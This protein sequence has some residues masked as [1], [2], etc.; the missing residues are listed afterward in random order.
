MNKLLSIS[1]GAV[2][3]F[4]LQGAA[5]A[6]PSP[7]SPGADGERH[8]MLEEADTNHDGKVSYEEFKAFHEK[9]MQEH[10][11]KLDA[12][13]DAFVDKEEMRKGRDMMRE[14]M[15][16]RMEKRRGGKDGQP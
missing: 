6:E 3:L 15:R 12:N 10:F 4:S 16:D 7:P 11:K 2:L 9:R 8:G 1:A 13:G 5:W 14:K